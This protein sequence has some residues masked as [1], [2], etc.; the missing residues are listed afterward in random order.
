[1]FQ[2]KYPEMF[3]KVVNEIKPYFIPQN[4]IRDIYEL[5]IDIAD[6]ASLQYVLVSKSGND[7]LTIDDMEAYNILTSDKNWI[8][9]LFLEVNLKFINK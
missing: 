9:K 4:N 5:F 7:I 2:T 8:K 1:M 3:N 6:K